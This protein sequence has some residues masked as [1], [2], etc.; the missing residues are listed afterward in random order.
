MHTRLPLIALLV[1]S[2]AALPASAEIHTYK[3]DNTHS[4]AN[5]EIRHVVAHTSGTFHDVQGKVILDTENIA[6]SS[7]E[8]NISVYSLNSSHLK[9]DIH[10]L[11]ED[12]LNARDYP[13]M[14]FVST[15]MSPVTPEKGSVTGNLTLHGVTRPVTLEYQILG[16]GKDP[17]GGM[18]IGLKA[19]GRLNRSDYGIN[20]GIPYGPVG[21]EVDITLLIEGIRLDTDGQP[22]SAAKAQEQN[23]KV[24]SF[25]APVEAAPQPVPVPATATPAASG[26][27]QPT[28][29]QPAPAATP[30]SKESVEDQ[31]KKKLLKGLFN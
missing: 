17:W 1:A 15:K 4:F 11:T 14:K 19:T 6:K 22:W 13:D 21:N 30:E 5:W 12:Y 2:A 8:A 23:A 9:R 18:R 28:T 16:L 25:P 27:T 10:L 20:K 29:T 7:V 3:I 26:S 31:L 24:I